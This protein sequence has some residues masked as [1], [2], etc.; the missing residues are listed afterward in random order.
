MADR[1]IKVCHVVSYRDPNYIRTRNLRAAIEHLEDTELLDATNTHRGLLR[2]FETLWKTLRIRFR[3][4]PDVYVLGFRG[5]EIFWLIR[6]VTIGKPL[7]FDEFM[8]P[9]DALISEG[10]GGLPGRFIG[11]LIF[12]LEWLCLKFSARCLTD[13]VLHRQFIADRFAVA[14]ENIDVVYV[15]A[16]PAE[17]AP[18]VHESGAERP[19]AVLFYG[20]FLPL[21]GMD[22]L[23]HA[24]KLV[25]DKP[26]EFRIIGG[27]GKTLARF[28]QLLDELNPGNVV[29]DTWVDFDELHSQV[30]PKA[31]LCLGGP[32][33]GTPQAS[34]V[35]TGKAFQFLAQSKATV[36]GRV[37]EPVAFV[38]RRNCLLV[39]QGSPE[40]L[41]K[42]F[43]WALANRQEL[44]AIGNNGRRLFEQQFSV[45]ALAK[46]LGPALRAVL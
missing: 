45:E 13:T 4:N 36:I 17:T 37:D 10:K 29:H 38:D 1:I 7:I 23:L 40:S 24:C 30:I 33:G 42:A 6:L 11:V 26:I 14:E 41:A 35:I 12:P 9:S 46:Q 31:D 18:A 39:E 8:S 25:E 2:Y 22:V 3:H 27:T 32:F 5:H 34:R 19:L 15:G 28:R 43:E 20:T 21:H 44:P 16:V